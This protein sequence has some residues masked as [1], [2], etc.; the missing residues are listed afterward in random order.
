MKSSRLF[1]VLLVAL[2]PS[3][4]TVTAPAALADACLPDAGPDACAPADPVDA[5]A[6][7][8]DRCKELFTDPALQDLCDALVGILSGTPLP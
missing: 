5:L 2:V 7:V 1:V 6:W 3:I 8:C 4:F